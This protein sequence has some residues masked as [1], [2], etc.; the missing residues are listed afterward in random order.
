[1]SPSS[2]VNFQITARPM[3]TATTTSDMI[4]SWQIA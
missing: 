1:M 3:I 4:V 2:E